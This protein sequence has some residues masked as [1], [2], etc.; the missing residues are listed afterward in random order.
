MKKLVSLSL[1]LA[2]TFS[3]FAQCT[4]EEV[5]NMPT[6]YKK[7]YE[8]N[9]KPMPE[10]E[11]WTN[12]F[13]TA[14]VEPALKS[15]KG[16]SGTWSPEGQYPVTAQGLVQSRISMYMNLLGCSSK[17]HTLYE[18]HESG[19]VLN[20]SFNSLW[21]IGE[22]S[23]H[24]EYQFVKGTDKKVFLNDVIDDSQIYRLEEQTEINTNNQYTCYHKDNYGKYF[25][26]S[27][28][29]VPLIIPITLKQVLEVIK[30]NGL[31]RITYLKERLKNP[32]LQDQN[33]FDQAHI[34]RE[35]KSIQIID[36]YIKSVTKELTQSF[37]GSTLFTDSFESLEDF[38][39]FINSKTD[40]HTEKLVLLNP[41]Y[42]NRIVSKSAP[43]FISVEL[44]TQG[45]S[46]S[47][48]KAFNDFETNL[49]LEKLQQMLVK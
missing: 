17:T 20:F 18:K 39:T 23:K 9:Y 36:D 5:S 14:V 31:S 21:P 33:K 26:I 11:K 49:D 45:N 4:Q 19:L 24:D 41:D 48:L 47:T 7:G 40:I 22:V 10:Q 13:F 29:G 1:T 30:K 32:E 38:N 12:P 27:K 42:F 16:L 43:Q 28:P 25:V 44:R 34:V 35:T 8:A 37:Q 3:S 6:V 46:P 2:I 15:T